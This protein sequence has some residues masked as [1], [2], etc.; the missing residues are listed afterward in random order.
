MGLESR[1]FWANRTFIPIYKALHDF[2]DQNCKDA[3][4]KIWGL[5]GIIDAANLRPDYE[6]QSVDELFE[7]VLKIGLEQIQNDHNVRDR[8]A[9]PARVSPPPQYTW[10]LDGTYEAEEKTP[11]DIPTSRLRSLK[12]WF[13]ETLERVLGLQGID[14]DSDPQVSDL[15]AYGR[16]Y[17]GIYS[18]RASTAEPALPRQS[19][20]S[21]YAQQGYPQHGNPR[22]DC[23]QQ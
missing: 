3:R 10:N 8:L 1:K 7:Q 22:L 13:T 18:E 15:G 19:L 5:L 17:S 9:A 14:S 16:N 21:G 6:G 20:R 11:T 4:G 23:Q 12:P 2:Q